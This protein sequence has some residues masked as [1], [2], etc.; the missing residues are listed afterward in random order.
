MH[1]TSLFLVLLAC[2][3]AA[4]YQTGCANYLFTRTLDGSCNN[5]FDANHGVAGSFYRRGHEGAEYNPDNTPVSNRPIERVISNK[6]ARPNPALRDSIRHSLFATQFGQFVNHDLNNNRFQD[7]DSINYPDKLSIPEL[8]DSFCFIFAD[9]LGGNF[10]MINACLPPKN[11]IPV[12]STKVSATVLVNGVPQVIND[13][14]SW[15]DLNTIYG[16]TPSISAALRTGT[17]GKLLTQNYASTTSP[18]NTFN[19]FQFG[20]AP[21]P[22]TC[23]NCPPSW[24]Q[25]NGQVPVNPLLN[26]TLARGIA[27]DKVFVSG[28]VRVGEN[29]AL[30]MFH[31]LFIRNHNRHA[32]RIAAQKPT[33]SDEQVFQAARSRN[34]AEYQAIVMYQYLPSEFGQFFADLVG[35]YEAYN[36][37]VDAEINIAFASAAFRYGHSSFRNY[38]PRDACANPTMFGQPAGNTLL[39]F[40][41]QTGGPITP[42]DVIGEVGTL[43]NVIRALIF[44]VTAPND[45]MVDDALRD[46]PF[47][48]PFAG[49][50]DILAL[51]FHRAR[52]NGV[53]NYARLQAFYGRH[54]DRVYGAQGCPGSYERNNQPDPLGCFTRLVGNTNSTL[55]QNLKDLYGKVNRIDPL[56]GLLLEQ[57][58][59]GTSFGYT[60][61]SIIADTYRRVRDGDRFWFENRMQPNPYGENKIWRIKQTKM[62]DLLRLNFNFPNPNQV[63]DNPFLSPF[64]YGQKLVATCGA[65][66]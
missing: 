6:I 11:Q 42:I 57:H 32:T 13:A 38:A 12:S 33:W 31:T 62:G 46:L 3:V 15:L 58:V 4:S 28:D 26:P 50:T 53:P 59:D 30:T 25:T 7:P 54:S 20:F 44:E 27:A 65:S 19:F 63:P 61:G 18:A 8:D 35:E 60:I 10:T 22:V 29:A 47:T 34:I 48:F 17:G 21:V 1:R 51:D 40:G 56:L 5:L 24:A 16:L 66:G 43:E 45:H 9:L 14:N 49:G 36:P 52:L 39:A 2:F 41:G 55:A 64:N 37:F 23:N